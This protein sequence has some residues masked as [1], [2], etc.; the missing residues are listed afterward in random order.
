MVSSAFVQYELGGQLFTTETIE[1]DTHNPTMNYSF[2]H[3]VERVSAEVGFAVSI[4]GLLWSTRRE[5]GG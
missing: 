4:A 1:K 2:V 3:H 5:R